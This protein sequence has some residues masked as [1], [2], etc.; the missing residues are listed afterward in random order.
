MTRVIRGHYEKYKRGGFIQAKIDRDN[1]WAYVHQVCVCLNCGGRFKNGDQYGHWC[2]GL[3]EWQKRHFGFVN[4]V[5]K[6]FRERRDRFM[7]GESASATKA[8]LIMGLKD[9]DI[10]PKPATCG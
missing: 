10:L 6:G 9:G 1:A 8:E 4:F 7:A 5:G 2:S 3:H